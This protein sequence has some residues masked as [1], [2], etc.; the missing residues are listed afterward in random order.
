[1]FLLILN[2]LNQ[3]DITNIIIYNNKKYIEHRFLKIG[4][5]YLNISKSPIKIHYLIVGGGGGGGSRHAGGGG[6]GGVIIANDVLINPGNYQLYV[7]KG[8]LGGYHSTIG[9][10]ENGENSSFFGEIA[11]GGGGGG[12]YGPYGHG[13]NGGSGGGASYQS[14][15][16]FSIKLSSLYGNSYGN[17]GGKGVD[18]DLCNYLHGG[19][20]GAGSPGEDATSLPIPKGGNGGDGIQWIDGKYYG[21]GGGGAVYNNAN[22]GNGGIGGGGGGNGFQNQGHCLKGGTNGL[23]SIDGGEDGCIQSSTSNCNAGNGIPNTGGGGGGSSHHY[24]GYSFGTGGAG[25]S[26]IIVIRYPYILPTND[27]KKIIILKFLLEFF[28]I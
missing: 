6:G 2:Y 15:E 18:G 23:G 14:N 20:G 17:N 21:G 28:L 10:G 27:K 19:G 5:H 3:G 1:M 13:K 24:P 11:L 7:G 12:S 22:A 4:K 9:L 8:G 26:G 16:G 25:G